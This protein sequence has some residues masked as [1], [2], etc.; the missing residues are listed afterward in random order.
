MKLKLTY[1]PTK[2]LL[3]NERNARFHSAEQ[4]EAIAN[5]IREFGFTNPILLD[6]D[7]I[8][9]AGHGRLEAASRLGLEEVPVINLGHLSDAKKR[10]YAIADNKIPLS[11]EWDMDMLKAEL[12][13]LDVDGFDLTLT[14]FSMDEL[15]DLLKDVD[16]LLPNEPVQQLPTRQN[17]PMEEYPE[18]EE[19]KDDLPQEKPKSE[20]PKATDERYSV[21]E[22][23]M[24]HENKL[25]LVEVLN[26]LR[27]ER[28]YEKIEDALMHLIRAY[29][30]GKF[31]D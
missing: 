30:E 19:A 16:A 22:L 5:S 24:I 25:L 9:I 18:E 23:V 4:V 12:D 8:I 14:G 21:F 31:N 13:A 10:A 20:S 26:N 2:S 7:D 15:D 1:K 29:N 17:E 11:A 27:Q 28:H 3:R 6:A